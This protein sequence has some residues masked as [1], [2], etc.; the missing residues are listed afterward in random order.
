MKIRELT[1]EWE[2]TAKGRMTRETYQVNLPVED[3]ARLAALHE[4]YPK[5]CVEELIT[6]LLSTALEELEECLPYK[7][8]DKVI[9]VDEMGDPLYDDV[10]PTPRF[11]EL[12]R[13]Y[14]NELTEQQQ[15]PQ[16]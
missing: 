6:D 15:E 9:A 2:R 11:L 16:H 4:M 13:K 1:Q 7:A 8:G 14:L 10:G 3:A 5:R 12:S